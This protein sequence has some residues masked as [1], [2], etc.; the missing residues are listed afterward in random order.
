MILG[1]FVNPLKLVCGCMR[2]CFPVGDL[3]KALV[4]VLNENMKKDCVGRRK[5]V[6]IYDI[7]EH[8]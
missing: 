7:L 5:E 2:I 1:V 4:A 8:N 6:Y 3:S